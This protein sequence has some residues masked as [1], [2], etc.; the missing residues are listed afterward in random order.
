[1][2]ALQVLAAYL[3]LTLLMHGLRDRLINSVLSATMLVLLPATAGAWLPSAV[4]ELRKVID[5]ESQAALAEGCCSSHQLAPEPCGQLVLVRTVSAFFSFPV[6]AV[7][8][9]E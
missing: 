9:H 2:L 8:N 3:V 5:L 6:N 7:Q 4:R 1:M